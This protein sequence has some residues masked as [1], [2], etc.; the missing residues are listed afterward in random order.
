MHMFHYNAYFVQWKS[1]Q[2]QS[3]SSEGRLF[4]AMYMY[5]FI[6]SCKIWDNGCTVVG[7]VLFIGEAIAEECQVIR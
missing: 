2:F 5:G 3:M 4:I 1:P 7:G 6:K